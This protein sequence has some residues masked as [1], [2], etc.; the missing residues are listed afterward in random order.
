M[1]YKFIKSSEKR[2]IEAELEELYGIDS[3]P[4][5]LL[6]EAGKKRI[7]AFSGSLSKEEIMLLSRAVKVELVGIYLISKKDEE[8]RLNFDAVSLLKDKITK[9]VLEINEE[10]FQ[11]WI[12]GQDL[13]LETQRGTV[14]IKYKN[15]FIGVGKS[16]GEKVF[17]Y[18]PKERKLKTQLIK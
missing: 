17:N 15:D 13:E 2:K 12:R 3:L 8:A 11:N 1:T 10:Q 6:I 16:N 18:I 5:Y 9:N 4:E 14:V 7:R